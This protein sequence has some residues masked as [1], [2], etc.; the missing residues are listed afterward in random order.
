MAQT[1]DIETHQ[2]TR[3]ARALTSRKRCGRGV[4]E[5]ESPIDSFLPNCAA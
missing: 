2:A 5:A 1:L 4:Q 3:D